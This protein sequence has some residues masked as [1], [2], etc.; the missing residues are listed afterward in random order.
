MATVNISFGGSATKRSMSLFAKPTAP[1]MIERR[2][3]ATAEI[4][5][6]FSAF[7]QKRSRRFTYEV[8]HHNSC[9]SDLTKVKGKVALRTGGWS[10]AAPVPRFQTLGPDWSTSP[11]MS[12]NAEYPLSC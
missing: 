11:D 12:G 6:K 8:P 7:F 10:M 3:T 5:R 4:R 9:D 1:R 2:V